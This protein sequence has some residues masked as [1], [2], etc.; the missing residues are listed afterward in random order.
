MGFF[1]PRKINHLCFWF[2]RHVTST[3]GRNAVSLPGAGSARVPRWCPSK[4]R[5]LDGHSLLKF[6]WCGPGFR[7][8]TILGEQKCLLKELP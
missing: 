3:D 7:V 8:I 1:I 4:T 2:W 6:Y 5:V